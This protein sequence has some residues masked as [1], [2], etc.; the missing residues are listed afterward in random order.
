ML[1]TAEDYKLPNGQIY[2]TY[3]SLKSADD[4]KALSKTVRKLA[5]S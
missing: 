5:I 3:P 4:Q 2:H 1:H